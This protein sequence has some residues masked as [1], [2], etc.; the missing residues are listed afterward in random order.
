MA[1]QT[2]WQSKPKTLKLEFK[3]QLQEGVTAKDVIL[4]VISKHGINFGTWPCD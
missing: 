2:L 1:T 3:G 4:Y